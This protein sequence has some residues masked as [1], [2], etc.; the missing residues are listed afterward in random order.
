M[1]FLLSGVNFSIFLVP[2][3]CFLLQNGI[4]CFFLVHN[5]RRHIASFFGYRI[6]IVFDI[7]PVFECTF[8]AV[9]A[10]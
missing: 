2:K 4:P 7:I 6:C 1:S 10:P 5:L 3:H 9:V 8:H